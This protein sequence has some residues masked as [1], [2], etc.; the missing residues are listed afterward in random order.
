[1]IRKILMNEADSYVNENA[2]SYKKAKDLGFKE[3]GFGY[4]ITEDGE[5]AAIST[6][7][8]S[9]L[10]ILEAGKRKLQKGKPTDKG[11]ER[12]Y[13]AAHDG[14]THMV[15]KDH[16]KLK[17]WS[18]ANAAA[19][20]KHQSGSMATK[21]KSIIDKASG[22]KK[23]SGSRP[24]KKTKVKSKNPVNSLKV[25]DDA[26]KIL[27]KKHAISS[28][29]INT[30]K[31]KNKYL[32]LMVE[33]MINIVPPTKGANRFMMNTEDLNIFKGFIDGQR[34]K[35]PNLKIKDDDVDSLL[36]MIKEQA[37]TKGYTTLMNKFAGKG[38]PPKGLKNVARGRA[39]L[40]HYLQTGGTSVVTGKFVPFS[41]MQL[42]HRVSLSNGGFD[43]PDNWD[44][45]EAKHNQFKGALEGD[46][47]IQKTLKYLDKSDEERDLV[48][49]QGEYKNFVRRSYRNYFTKH[50]FDSITK[51][52]IMEATGVGGKEFLKAIADVAEIPT[53]VQRP[54]RASG[55]AGGTGLA[56]MPEIK[57]RVLNTIKLTSRNAN[58]KTDA[59][60]EKL[61]KAQK[62]KETGVKSLQKIVAQQK[63]D[64]KTASK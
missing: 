51:E 19:V 53:Y 22:K 52:D 47:L 39:V 24:A 61:I 60:L 16:A 30:Q 6:D 59:H 13:Y 36:D 54:D 26:N 35:L 28:K 43:G 3:T 48:K 8:G 4:F 42:D 27:N 31:K 25:R 45:M 57:K 11:T 44:W 20:R 37:G 63:K 21:T 1:V 38:E 50:G 62:S 32:S 29:A 2:F 56:K 46:K 64:K 10:I 14:E 33:S 40:K 5:I 7:N 34:A 17:G 49:A 58:K 55:R 9:R 18:P 41:D 15:T 12:F 23:T